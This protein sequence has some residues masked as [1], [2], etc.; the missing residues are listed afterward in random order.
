MATLVSRG[1][2]TPKFHNQQFFRLLEKEERPKYSVVRFMAVESHEL[3]PVSFFNEALLIQTSLYDLLSVSIKLKRKA[4]FFYRFD[5][6]QISIASFLL[7]LKVQ[8]PYALLSS[9]HIVS[10]FVT[11]DTLSFKNL[12]LPGRVIVSGFVLRGQADAV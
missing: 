1:K 6:D 7:I 2:L 11:S 10:S 4:F 8:L 3:Y 9:C 12:T 5:T